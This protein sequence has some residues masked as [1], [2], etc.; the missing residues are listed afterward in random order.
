VKTVR[1]ICRLQEPIF[2]AT[3]VRQPRS[4]PLPKYPASADRKDLFLVLGE[5]HHRTSPMAASEPQRLVILERGLYTGIVIVCVVGT[6]KTSACMY[7][8]VE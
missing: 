3:S 4:A 5:Q 8:Y 7:P 2:L 1:H 6:G